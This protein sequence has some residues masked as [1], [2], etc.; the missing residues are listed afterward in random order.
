MHG[1]NCTFHNSNSYFICL[2]S[3]GSIDIKAHIGSGLRLSHRGRQRREGV[4]YKPLVQC[5]ANAQV[6]FVK[7][8]EG[9]CSLIT[10][11]SGSSLAFGNRKSGIS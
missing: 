3:K 9:K 1:W 5:S 6:T 11:G 8:E 7:G 2:A 4:V 10:F